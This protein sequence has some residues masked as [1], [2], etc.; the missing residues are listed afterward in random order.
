MRTLSPDT[1]TEVERIHIGLIRKA[2]IYQRLEI[3]SS[4][5]R[6]TRQLSWQGICERYPEETEE[7]R[8]RRFVFLLYKDP[9]LAQEVV[10]TISRKKKIHK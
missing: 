8:L 5:I 4:L 2:A 6:T 7:E 3:V 10:N 1:P 9:C